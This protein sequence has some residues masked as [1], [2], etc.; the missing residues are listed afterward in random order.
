MSSAAPWRNL[1]LEVWS[2]VFDQLDDVSH[3]A[4]CRLVCKS[5]DPLAE[6]A[7][8][9]QGCLSDKPRAQEKYYNQLAKKPALTQ[10]VQHI[11]ILNANNMYFHTEFL[12]LAF[13]SNVKIIE[14][15]KST[16]YKEFDTGIHSL[17]LRI[18]QHKSE[19]Y[20]LEYLMPFPKRWWDD[21]HVRAFLFFKKTL[22]C[23]EL[24]FTCNLE[25]GQKATTTILACRDEFDS[26]RTIKLSIQGIANFTQV[27]SLLRKCTPI[28]ELELCLNTMWCITTLMESKEALEEWMEHQVEKDTSVRKLHLRG[29]Y[30][31]PGIVHYLLYKFPRLASASIHDLMKLDDINTVLSMVEALK[32]VPFLSISPWRTGSLPILK[33]VMFNMKSQQNTLCISGEFIITEQ[34]QAMEDIISH[35]S[36]IS[37]LDV[38]YGTPKK[39]KLSNQLPSLYRVL[40]AVAPHIKKLTIQDV[41]IQCPSSSYTPTHCNHLSQLEIRAAIVDKLVLSSLSMI[42]PNLQY[43]TLNTC[44][45]DDEFHQD[46]HVI[47]PHTDFR[48]LSIVT[49]A[50]SKLADDKAI[51]WLKQEIDIKNY[52][53]MKLQVTILDDQQTH[54]FVLKAGIP[55]QFKQISLED[56]KQIADKWPKTVIECKS[57]HYL[58]LKLGRL[59]D[60]IVNVKAAGEKGRIEPLGDWNQSCRAVILSSLYSNQQG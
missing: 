48:C 55:T 50:L 28:Q 39:W 53:M 58:K 17:L 20:T 22:K 43:L 15:Y 4:A 25:Y 37:S 54:Y 49:M 8:F 7:M 57:I 36:A 56:Y 11:R 35:L 60:I 40:E 38:S 10:L 44:F 27:E 1:P 23:L 33:A 51:V 3:L 13:T 46:Y 6:R 24:D 41:D 2:I 31:D 21:T 14:G 18:A 45:L 19:D 26:L 52:Q 32:E 59:M 47:M 12:E 42:A 29:Q 34:P 30:F 16:P 9:K 5:W